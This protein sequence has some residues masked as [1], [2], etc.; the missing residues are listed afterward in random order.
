[1]RLDRCSAILL[2]LSLGAC[3]SQPT[4]PTLAQLRGSW[5]LIGAAV[6]AG[7]R[8]PTVTFSE[9]GAMNGIAGVNQFRGGV[10]VAALEKGH[11][12]ATAMASTRM[13]GTA[14]AMAF[15]DSFL[16]GL[17]SAHE[18]FLLDNKLELR[19]GERVLMRFQQ[20]AHASD[21]RHKKSR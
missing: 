10:D 17:A 8:V 3:A 7:A 21:S 2:G 9:G 12:Q 1:M 11:W 16:Q 4:V 20:V 14:E 19:D 15:E 5:H 13:A 18:A 6:P